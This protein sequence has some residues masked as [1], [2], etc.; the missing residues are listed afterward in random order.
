M[1]KRVAV[2]VDV[3]LHRAI[4]LNVASTHCT[5]SGLVN[6][7]LRLYLGLPRER[8]LRALLEEGYAELSDEAKRLEREFEALDRDSLTHQWR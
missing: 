5:I 1:L 6:E 2:H 3:R 8:V 4:K 7:A